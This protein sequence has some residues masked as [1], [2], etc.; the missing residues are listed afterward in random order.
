[1]ADYLQWCI[2]TFR[3]FETAELEHLVE[4]LSHCMEAE[5]TSL[6]TAGGS[7]QSL[8]WDMIGVR[9]AGRAVAG[10]DTPWVRSVPP[11]VLARCEIA[12]Q[13]AAEL[14]AI[15]LW[16]ALSVRTW[17]MDAAQNGHVAEW[18]TEKR[19]VVDELAWRAAI[20]NARAR[21]DG[22]PVLVPAPEEGQLYLHDM[23]NEFVYDEIADHG[24]E[25]RAVQAELLGVAVAPGPDLVPLGTEQ[26]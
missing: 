26:S 15:S 7:P 8:A 4:I 1:M 13:K 23:I 10:Q 12:V 18:L 22:Q 2:R 19:A 11:E 17:L 16:A 24:A 21:L 20:D 14:L 3:R 6:S 25:L 9:A 5:A